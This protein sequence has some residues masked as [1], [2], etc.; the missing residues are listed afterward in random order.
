MMAERLRFSPAPTGSLH[1]GGARTALFNDLVARHTGGTL[2][3]R[4]EDT[5]LARSDASNEPG[6]IADLRWLGVHWQEGPDEGGPSGP[7]RQSER[8]D[9]YAE[10]V[11]RLA[12]SGNAYRCFCDEPML[13]ADRDADVAEGRAPR[14]RGACRSLSPA[15]AA[16][17]ARE[18][19]AYCWRFA[20]P[21]SGE[22]VVTDL[23]HGPVRFDAGDIA[24][25]VI[26]RADGGA[27]YDL[28][29]AVDDAAMGITL[30]VRG[31]DHLPNTPRQVLLLRA[32]GAEVPRYAHVPLVIGTDGRPL[33]KS[34]GA[35]PVSSLRAQ[36]FLPEAVANHLALLGW[37][38]PA[39]R[40]VMSRD[41]IAAAFDLGR[42]S[43]SS[44]AH[45]P[46][47]L[48]WLNRKHMARLATDDRARL[49]AGFLPDLPG[50]DRATAAAILADE[51]EV[52]GEA[53]VLVA[54][55]ASRLAPDEEAETALKAPT[56]RAALEIARASLASSGDAASL[57]PA[58]RA[59]GLAARDA[60]PAVRAAVTGRAHG[61][62]VATI[63][64]LLGVGEALDRIGD[65]LA[66]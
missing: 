36:G 59:A 47:R 34:R 49:V 30:V 13:E 22:I 35:E 12:A 48:R 44:P 54:G 28:A 8:A 24:D 10:A 21:D 62:P 50:V 60:M 18:G 65:A 38:D 40:E 11:A 14:Y 6:L 45:D 7:Y 56:A 1:L 61:L 29:C 46:A 17:R 27:L 19:E 5:D 53:A 58:F 37:S 43:G 23:V 31:D 57:G 41:E 52:A 20:V 26:A 39:G 2:V 66:G 15:E 9:L 64:A 55:I 32:L 4:F 3:L 16:R 63:V 25:F 33:S 42:V 51:V